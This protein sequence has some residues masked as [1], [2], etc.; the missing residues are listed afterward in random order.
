MAVLIRLTDGCKTK[1]PSPGWRK[2]FLSIRLVNIA[3][4]IT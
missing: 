1:N 2:D 4:E 3:I